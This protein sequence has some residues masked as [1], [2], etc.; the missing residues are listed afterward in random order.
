MTISRASSEK[1]DVSSSQI[2]HYLRLIRLPNIFTVPSNI[3]VGY[4]ALQADSTSQ[5]AGLISSSVLL[6]ISGIVFNDLFDIELDRKNRS[7][8]PLPLGKISRRNA[9]AIAVLTL[10][11][12][13]VIALMT[14]GIAALWVTVSLSAIILAYDYGLKSN[15]IAGT[16]AMAGA[17][18]L[19]VVL[20]ASPALLVLLSVSQ[21]RIISDHG[22]QTL[23]IA[24]TSMFFYIAS[25]MVL[26]RTEEKGAPETRNY[27]VMGI[28][29]TTITYIAITGYL[30]GWEYWFF[31]PLGILASV[32]VAS[33]KRYSLQSAESTQNI[34]RNLILSIIILD[35]V[36]ITASAGIVLGAAIFLLLVPAVMLGRKMYVT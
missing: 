15:A 10:F 11:G 24:T 26:S 21:E 8:R 30:I 20:G 4:L 32:V 23:A 36:F 7:N 22:F 9:I 12:A 35:S 18:F 29:L 14:A 16:V 33:F 19:N 17:R 34:I 27:V 6:Y 31:L 3:I 1:R 28:I 13:N 2:W 25:I 5:L